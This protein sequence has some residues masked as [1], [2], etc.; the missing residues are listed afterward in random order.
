MANLINTVLLIISINAQ[1]A[2][3]ASIAY[4]T[5]KTLTINNLC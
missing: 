1:Y 4:Q 5:F 3:K 2:N